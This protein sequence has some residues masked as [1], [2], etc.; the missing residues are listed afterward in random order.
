[1]YIYIMCIYIYI[2]SNLMCIYIYI[3]TVCET[4]WTSLD[5]EIASLAKKGTM[6]IWGQQLTF[7]EALIPS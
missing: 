4:K 3:H 1:M 7:L 6:N 5:M 2:H